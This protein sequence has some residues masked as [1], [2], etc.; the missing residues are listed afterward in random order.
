VL[1]TEANE[2]FICHTPTTN[3]R[4]HYWYWDERNSKLWHQNPNPLVKVQAQDASSSNLDI[5]IPIA[6]VEHHSIAI[7]R[8]DT[9]LVWEKQ[10]ILL[11]R[12]LA[13][14]HIF[15]CPFNPLSC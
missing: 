8:P 12:S 5:S 3:W 6:R 11:S 10:Q 4:V 15:Q 13:R 2:Q 1:R 7:N 14:D 9:L